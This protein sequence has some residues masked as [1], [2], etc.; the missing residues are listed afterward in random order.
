MITEPPRKSHGAIDTPTQ[1]SDS[2]TSTNLDLRVTYIKWWREGEVCQNFGDYISEYPLRVPVAIL[3][4]GTSNSPLCVDSAIPDR[5][6]RA[7]ATPF[8]RLA[9]RHAV[10]DCGNNA[11]TKTEGQRLHL[12][13]Q[14]PS[15]A[16]SLNQITC[17]SR[18]PSD[19][20]GEET[21]LMSLRPVKKISRGSS[22]YLVPDWQ[23][24]WGQ[25]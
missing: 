6:R 15:P 5:A 16:R 7:N 8:C 23:N 17:H 1:H 13:R 12:A 3:W 11:F 18:I 21:A 9:A 22:F 14:P 20:V 19:S 4:S 10:R 25:I 24:S 2:D